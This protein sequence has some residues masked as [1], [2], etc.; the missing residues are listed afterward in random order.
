MSCKTVCN[1]CKRLAISTAV[2]FTDGNLIINLPENSYRDCEKVCIIIAQ[3][4]PA[5]VT[6]DAPTFITIGDGTVQYP[7]T[8]RCC[9]QV[10]AKD[11]ETRRRYSTRVSTT[12]TGGTF[13]LLCNLQRCNTNNLTAI[14]GTAP[15]APAAPAT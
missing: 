12:P 13:R 1:L 10:T 11:L 5:T 7:L 15:A 14:D 4:F 3:T 9:A 8:D 2:T 6:R